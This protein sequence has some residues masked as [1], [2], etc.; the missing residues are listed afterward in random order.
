MRGRVSG[1]GCL[2]LSISFGWSCTLLSVSHVASLSVSKSLCSLHEFCSQ[3]RGRD[4]HYPEV[5]ITLMKRATGGCIGSNRKEIPWRDYQLAQLLGPRWEEL[6]P[7]EVSRKISQT[8]IHRA[9]DDPGEDPSHPGG[10]RRLAHDDIH[11]QFQGHPSV[12]A[13]DSQWVVDW[14]LLQCADQVTDLG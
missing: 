14:S 13:Q 12:S 3:T 10:R 2:P 11:H 9:D 1:L 8:I 7:P 5:I 4:R 6:H